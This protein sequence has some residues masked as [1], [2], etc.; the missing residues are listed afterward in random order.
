MLIPGVNTSAASKAGKRTFNAA[1]VGYGYWG[2]NILRN[3]IELPEVAQIA[4]CDIRED[5][6]NVVGKM[7]PDIYLEQDYKL[8]AAN[9]EIDAVC[10][11]TPASSHF[12]IARCALEHGKHVFIEKPFTANSE[13]ARH[14]ISLAEERNVRICVDHT[15]LY[16]GAVHKIK[17]YIDGEQLGEISYLDCRRVNLGIYQPDVNVLWDLASH[18][19]SIIQF[20]I[21]EKPTYIRAIGRYNTVHEQVDMAYLFLHYHSGL[22]VQVHSSWASPVKI[23]Q[24]TIG[25]T[26]KMII[27]DDIEPS[28]KLK[29]YDYSARVLDSDERNHILVDYRLGDVSIPK[30]S[31]PEPL[32]SALVD[33]FQSIHAQKEPLSNAIAALEIISWLE[34]AQQS[35]SQNGTLIS[36]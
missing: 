23:R 16:N 31:N 33:F 6:L 25:G 21:A 26:Q 24:L 27:Y 11:A 30:F 32:K 19:L 22:I 8:V 34:K 1:L 14:L 4:V 29:V 12:E 28:H 2:K 20:L 18:D 5:C 9:P 7:F 10:I 13:D 17:E 15:F 35:L 3:L 36:L